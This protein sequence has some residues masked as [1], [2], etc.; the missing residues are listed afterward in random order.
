MTFSNNNAIIKSFAVFETNSTQI[1]NN[2]PI[3]AIDE[4]FEQFAERAERAAEI[5]RERC[6]DVPDIVEPG[7][8]FHPVEVWDEVP[9]VRDNYF[10]RREKLVS[11]GWEN[12]DHVNRLLSEDF[13]DYSKIQAESYLAAQ[14]AFT[15]GKNKQIVA[16]EMV[17]LPDFQTEFEQNPEHRAYI[18]EVVEDVP[19]VY[20]EGVDLATKTSV[21]Q[22]IVIH[23]EATVPQLSEYAEVSERHIRNVLPVLVAEG[24]VHREKRKSGCD[25]WIDRGITNSYLDNLIEEKRQLEE[26]E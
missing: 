21:A 14:F 19:F 12:Q 22:G 15:F 5:Q 4:Y 16:Y 17:N 13:R 2:T 10:E 26:R 8:G 18:F 9:H 20:C 3:T 6:G 25:L 1:S 24:L 11:G 7:E 23:Q